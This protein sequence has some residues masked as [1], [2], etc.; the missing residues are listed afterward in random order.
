MITYQTLIDDLASGC[1]PKDQFRIGLEHEQFSYDLKTNKPLS[2][3]GSPGIK[4][5]LETFAKTYGWE[6]ILEGD[7]LIALKDAQSNFVTLEPGGQFEYSGAPM[8]SVHEAKEAMDKFYKNL[9]VV[10]Q[11]MGVGFLAKGFHPTWRLDEI[12]TMPKQRAK[13]MGPYMDRIKS[14]GRHVMYSAC[15]A[16]IN[17]DHSSE[18]EMV[19]N[20][21]LSLAV[22]PVVIAL[23]ANSSKVEGKDIGYSSYRSHL[24]NHTDPD[25]CGILPF[26]F[27]EGMGF[28]RYVDYALDVP[29][30]Y[31]YRDGQYI[32]VSGLSF[33]DFM[34]GQLPGREGEYPTIDDWRDHLTTL[35][36]E[37]RLKHYLELRGADSHEP[38][39]IYAMAAFWTGLFYNETA[40]DKVWSMVKDWS[41]DDH[42]MIR[43]VVPKSGLDT[44]IPDGRYLSAL[45]RDILDVLSDD[46]L[47]P[48]E[49]VLAA[50]QKSA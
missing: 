8:S 2:Y 11:N 43:D 14:M 50:S 44:P 6:R 24:W 21:R 45:A 35:F 19:K 46:N 37:V 9:E 32:D 3:N 40:R 48:F 28:A 34:A 18:E 47:Q 23:M 15:T 17:L 36:P 31:I 49:D 13:I 25:R 33:R 29:M 22:Q 7:N 30:Y 39:M 16:Q 41:V 38:N 5:L 26:A 27:E 1:K 10:A 42:Q 4:K 12:S 20:L